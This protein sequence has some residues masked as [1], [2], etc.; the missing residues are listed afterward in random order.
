MGHERS[1][2]KEFVNK[3]LG[4]EEIV[5]KELKDKELLNKDLALAKI[6]GENIF[7]NKCGAQILGD[8]LAVNKEWGYFSDKDTEIHKFALCEKC[9][10]EMIKTFVT[11]PTQ[12]L[13]KEVM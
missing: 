12:E 2:M 13:K 9:Y 7:C 5:N 4:N 6:L 11:L 1:A 8:Y 10:D 3:E